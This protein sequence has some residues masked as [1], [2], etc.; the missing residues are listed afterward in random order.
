MVFTKISANPLYEQIAE[1]VK[2]QV[3]AGHW[4]PGSK[5]P[6]EPELASTFKTSRTTLRRAL[7]LLAKQ[8][9][10]SRRKGKGTFIVSQVCS[11]RR[12]RLGM[13]GMSIAARTDH[14]RGELLGGIQKGLEQNGPGLEIL[15][16]PSDRDFLRHVRSG[17]VDGLF[18]SPGERETALVAG[19]ML[20][21]VPHVVLNASFS[22]LK[23]HD[24]VL[25]DTDNFG[26]AVA[27]V[28]HLIA[29]GH[30]VI[31]HICSNIDRC[32]IQDRLKGYFAAMQKQDLL[33]DESAVIESG[34]SLS[35][36][37]E[38]VRVYLE[39]HPHITAVFADG[40]TPTMAVY[41]AARIMGRRI[42]ED[43]S[44]IGFDDPQEARFLAPPLTTVKQPTFELGLKAAQMMRRQLAGETLDVRQVYLDT[45]LIVRG[46]CDAVSH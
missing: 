6:P 19:P 46:S 43:L 27:A 41:D 26:G 18:L 29:L 13:L 3:R 17:D 32:N 20:N 36:T 8:R 28:E 16:L 4:E 44:V 1:Y 31:A 39:E 37:S 35:E 23:E 7:A 22:I 14:H 21:S 38:R 34:R 12:T 15:F 2:K 5:L 24:N 45:K 9:L 33:L 11:A 42:P 25:I 10:I 40:F 30:R